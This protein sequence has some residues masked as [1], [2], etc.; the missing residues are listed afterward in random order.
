MAQAVRKS[1]RKLPL[2]VGRQFSCPPSVKVSGIGRL[3]TLV[4]PGVIKRLP[5][6]A[7]FGVQIPTY[8]AIA[9]SSASTPIIAIT[10]F[11]L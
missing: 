9:S 1:L 11:M 2:V 3:V 4:A 6:W 5:V 8:A 10:R 7:D